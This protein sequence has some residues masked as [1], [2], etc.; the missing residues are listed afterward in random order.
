MGIVARKPTR[1]RTAAKRAP[2]AEPVAKRW[3]SEAEQTLGALRAGLIDAL[4]I[5]EGTRD[6]VY[7]LRTFEELEQANTELHE[8]Q[9]RLLML[10]NE[11]ERLMQDLHD[12]C[13]QSIYAV[14]LALEDCR[15]VIR[16][17][18]AEAV[19]KIARAEASLNLVIQELRAFISGHSPHAA[20]DLE[21][22]IGRTIEALGAHAPAF[23]IDIDRR[24]A[25]SLP[26]EHATQLL[27]ILREAVS[28][29]V[30]H[31]KA[32]AGRIS[33]KRRGSK[34]QLEVIDD[35]EGFDPQSNKAAGL[36]LHHIAARVQKLGGTLRLISKRMKGSRI[37]VDI[38]A[39]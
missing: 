7:A 4:V 29:I 10:L 2:R 26:H 30:R 5:T 37:I 8:S 11:R 9:E 3:P 15:A 27:Q 18:P 19:Q 28:N 16:K 32:K 36:G 35:G 22:E 31:A 24:L 39:A 33:L 34:V 38:P 20:V 1:R 25:S 23:R 6:R 17:D 14:G 12:G 13:I 21:S